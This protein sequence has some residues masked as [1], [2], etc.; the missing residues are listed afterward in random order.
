MVTLV[1]DHG[2]QPYALDEIVN[3]AY[4]DM[5]LGNDMDQVSSLTKIVSTGWTDL[6][7]TQATITRQL[8]K[9]RD[10]KIIP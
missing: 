1:A 8:Q 9:L 4:L 3:W 2:L 10:S 6:W 7:N 5:A